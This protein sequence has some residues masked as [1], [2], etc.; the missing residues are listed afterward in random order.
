[1][2]YLYLALDLGVILFPFL[3]SFDKKVAY[4][5]QWKSVLLALV[6]VGI[7]FLIH[8]YFFTEHGIWGFEPAY[9]SGLY[10]ANLPLE[11]VLFFVVVPFAC[12]FI[13]ACVKQYFAVYSFKQFNQLFYGFIGVYAV[14]VLLLGWSNWY[15]SMA[16]IAAL[17]LLFY[18]YKKPNIQFIP[19]AFSLSMIPFFMMNSVLTG[20]ATAT[21]V[22]WYNNSENL[23]FR[24]G[25]IPV[26]D[27]LYSFVL[28]V[29]NILIVEWHSQKEKPAIS[30]ES[31]K[32]L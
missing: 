12:V 2:N 25:T 13:Y 9:L 29:C 26:E 7:P 27:V 24:W 8:D 1:M 5:T 31:H 10:I 4:Y 30:L 23:N 32:L 21:P 18:V 20:L 22:V 17:I 15:S 16:S 11:E 3:L 6:L 28:I 14:I 19:F